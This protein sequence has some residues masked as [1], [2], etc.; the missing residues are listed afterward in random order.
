MSEIHPVTLPKWGLEMAEGSIAAWH[1]AEGADI[2]KGADL[3]DIETDKIVN[4]LDLERGGTV[5]RLLAEP[6]DV[7]PVGALIAVLAPAS[8]SDAEIEAF[9]KSYTPI[10]VSFEPGDKSSGAA[11]PPAPE[12]PAVEHP[13]AEHPAAANAASASASLSAHDLRQRNETAHATPIARR[14]ANQRG[15]DLTTITGTG[16]SGRISQEDVETASAASG[17]QPGA[18]AAPAPEPASASA[19][20]PDELKAV[21]AAAHASPIARKAADK[22]GIDLSQ[23]AGTGKNGRISL[24]DV[25]AAAAALGVAPSRPSAESAAP[26]VDA[27]AAPPP[28]QSA[29]ARPAETGRV[30][31]T[32]MRRSIAQTLVR[33][34]QTVP[35]FYTTVDI[36]AD[37]L[38]SLRQMVNARPG[39]PAKVSVNDFILRAAALA[40]AEHRDVNVH[41]F[42]DGIERFGTA[43]IAV[44]VAVEGGLLAPV[45]R[46]VGAKS[47]SDIALTTASLAERARTRTL[48]GDDLKDATFTV[49]NLGM[50]GVRAF[51][52]IITPPQ[53]AVLAVGG[54]RREAREDA[55]SERGFRFVSVLS[56][57]LSAD[58]RAVDGALAARFL[59]SLRERLEDP[60][61]LLV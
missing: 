52:A 18:E 55:G 43:D 13:A 17:S 20:S 30:A 42:E 35:H 33:A 32:S 27:P 5:R 58:H 4:T 1:V 26:A 49:S 29:P 8:V 54:V 41:V 47:V 56:A 48:S 39:A 60:V 21:N 51:D 24:E 25:E 11:E 46:D 6:G 12:H 3:V 23:V 28:K 36:D 9:V 40:L 15:I 59:K 19:L 57:T 14:I 45:V 10:D 22:L 38:M 37:A 34:K 44:A 53:A 2:E 7:L 16:R 50:F 61:S 31:F